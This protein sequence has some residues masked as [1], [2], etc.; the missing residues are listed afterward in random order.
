MIILVSYKIYKKK[1]KKNWKNSINKNKYNENIHRK[2]SN[3]K[4]IYYIY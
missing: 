4:I 2:V 3:L 1:L